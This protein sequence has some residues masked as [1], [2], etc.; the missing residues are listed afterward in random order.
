MAVFNMPVPIGFVKINTS[1]TFAVELANTLSGCTKPVT[2]KPY[3]GSG[4]A[5]V[6]PPTNNAPA[7][8]TLSAPPLKISDKIF[9]S[10]FSG[11]V[12]ILSAIV[13]VPPIA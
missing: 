2:D 10:K 12:T 1:P 13:G 7:S 4:S 3:L 11:N 5:T 6:C 9:G 8:L